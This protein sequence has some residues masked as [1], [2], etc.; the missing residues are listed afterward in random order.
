M[1]ERVEASDDNAKYLRALVLLQLR[2]ASLADPNFRSELLL[3]QAGFAR[4]EIASLTGKTE[5][6][7]SKMIERSRKAVPRSPNDPDEGNTQEV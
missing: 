7:V 6:A 4:K 5:A 3:N 2:A 1:V